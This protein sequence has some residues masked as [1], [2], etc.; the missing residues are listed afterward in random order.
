MVRSAAWVPMGMDL[1]GATGP[2]AVEVKMET[3]LPALAAK[4]SPA[5]S[6]ARPL[7]PLRPVVVLNGMERVGCALF[8]EPMGYSTMDVVEVLGVAAVV[9]VAEV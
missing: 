2:V 6:T 3:P 1:D 8:W 9:V 7:M 4:M 5:V